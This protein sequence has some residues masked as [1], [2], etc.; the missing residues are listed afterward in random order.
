MHAANH[1]SLFYVWPPTSSSDVRFGDHAES[2]QIRCKVFI[3]ADGTVVPTRRRA[4]VKPTVVR[5]R[6]RIEVVFVV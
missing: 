6:E 4:A 5:T 3:L 1:S 2:L